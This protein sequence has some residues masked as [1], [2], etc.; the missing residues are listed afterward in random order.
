MFVMTHTEMSPWHVVDAN[1]QKRARL[2]CIAHLLD[3][4]PWRDIP[5]E[6]PALPE[7][8]P[9]GDYKEHR[10]DVIRIPDRW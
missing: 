5:W 2:N 9:Q 6:A 1:D 10:P 8:Q 3:S 7:R 4:I